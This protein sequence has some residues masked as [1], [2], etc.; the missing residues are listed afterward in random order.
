MVTPLLRY[1]KKA[2]FF[3]VPVTAIAGLV[4]A[5]HTGQSSAYG[6]LLGG[7]GPLTLALALDHYLN[8][9]TETRSGR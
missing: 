8:R 7:I 1:T 5:E 9:D 3:A 4:V 2:L 6:L